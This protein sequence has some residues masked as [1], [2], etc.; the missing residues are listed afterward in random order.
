[1]SNLRPAAGGQAPQ[2]DPPLP[3]QTSMPLT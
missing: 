1:M 3:P 2:R